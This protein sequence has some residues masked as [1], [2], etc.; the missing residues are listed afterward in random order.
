[1]F[2]VFLLPGAQRQQNRNFPVH[3]Q[4]ADTMSGGRICSC[5]LCFILDLLY[6]SLIPVF[7]VF[8]LVQY[9]LQCDI[10]RK[11]GESDLLT[12]CIQ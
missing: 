4:R 12:Y 8:L 7:W 2:C 9:A 1:M 6:L 5:L 11:N 10:V 3:I